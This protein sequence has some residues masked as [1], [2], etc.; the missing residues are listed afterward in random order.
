[1]GMSHES[2]EILTSLS[3]SLLLFCC[4]V[5]SLGKHTFIWHPQITTYERM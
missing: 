4:H 2:I 1:M 5:L 3:C